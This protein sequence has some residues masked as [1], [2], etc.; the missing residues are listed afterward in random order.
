MKRYIKVDLLSLNDESANGLVLYWYYLTLRFDS[1]ASSQSDFLA[2]ELIDIGIR[3]KK[4]LGYAGYTY[5]EPMTIC[6]NAE[7]FFDVWL[8][9]DGDIKVS[10]L[11]SGIDE[12][13]N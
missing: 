10:K 9:T 5:Y 13:G 2:D 4:Y 8:D 12:S 7:T 3:L 6:M 11:Y 1:A